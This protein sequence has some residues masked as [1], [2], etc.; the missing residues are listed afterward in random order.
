M[1]RLSRTRKEIGAVM[2]TAGLAGRRLLCPA[3]TS[4][5]EADTARSVIF[6]ACMAY[7]VFLRI[8]HQSL[9]L[10]VLCHTLAQEGVAASFITCSNMYIALHRVLLFRNYRLHFKS[11]RAKIFR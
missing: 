6:P 11:D 5:P 7:A 4:F 1:C 3:P 8:L 9:P 10:H 2:E